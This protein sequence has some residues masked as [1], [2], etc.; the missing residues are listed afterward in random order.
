MWTPFARFVTRMMTRYGTRFGSETTPGFVVGHERL[1]RRNL[2]FLTTLPSAPS[3]P[4]RE[5]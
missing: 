4:D 2:S 1:R 3:R 5:R